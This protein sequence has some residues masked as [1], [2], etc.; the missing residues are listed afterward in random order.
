VG[1]Q[2]EI[3]R[4]SGHNPVSSVSAIQ[5]A[6]PVASFNEPEPINPI[7]VWHTSGSQALITI[8]SE[9]SS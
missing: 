4:Q 9:P 1:V 8:P 7:A 5:I 6:E 3:R 2:L